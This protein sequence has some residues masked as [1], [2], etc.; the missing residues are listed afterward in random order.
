MPHH[1]KKKFNFGHLLHDI[2][3]VVKAV[4]AP[5]INQQNQMAKLGEKAIT[6]VSTFS[7]NMILPIAIVGGIIIFSQLKK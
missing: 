1:H 3:G 6:G 2:G 7:N 5:I 4:E